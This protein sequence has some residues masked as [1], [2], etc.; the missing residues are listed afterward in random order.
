MRRHLMGTFVAGCVPAALFGSL[1]PEECRHSVNVSL[2][3][4]VERPRMAGARHE[5]QV[6]LRGKIRKNLRA[7][8][9]VNAPIS[10]SLNQKDR[11]ANRS[12]PVTWIQESWIEARHPGPELQRNECHWP[13]N[14]P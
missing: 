9:G 8:V 5:P 10:V 7:A 14:G 6:L 12:G 11:D 3:I 4:S 13:G 1:P 2:G